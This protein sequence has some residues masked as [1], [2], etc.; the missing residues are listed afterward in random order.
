MDPIIV[1]QTY[2]YAIEHVWHAVTEPEAVAEWLMPGDFQAV[3]GH[4]FQF[5]CEPH[6]EFDGVIDVEILAVQKPYR[7]VYSWKTRN[8]PTPSTVT[9]RLS[10]MANEGTHEACVTMSAVL[11]CETPLLHD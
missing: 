11:R 9:V 5:R 3:V 4:R 1:E 10:S 7:F 2:P 6:P 8:M